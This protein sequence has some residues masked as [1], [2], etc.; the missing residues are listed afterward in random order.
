MFR[1]LLV[2]DNVW[3]RQTVKEML[4]MRFPFMS[5]EA[6]ANG[7]EAMQRVNTSVPDLIFMDIRLPGENGIRLTQKIKSFYPEITIAV[8]TSY[9]LPEYRE[10]AYQSGAD[11]FLAKGSSSG[12]Q[13]A[14]LVESVFAT[15][16][17]SGDDCRKREEE[18]EAR[19]VC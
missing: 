10:Y 7:K 11:H 12:D 15:K 9:D 6:A 13:I 16:H 19:L 8:L 1:I 14:D 3:L 4:S 18:V 17:S 2:E 5:V